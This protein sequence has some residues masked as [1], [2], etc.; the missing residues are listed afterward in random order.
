MRI[1]RD[2]MVRES[3]VSALEAEDRHRLRAFEISWLPTP[4]T[5]GLR[6]TPYSTTGLF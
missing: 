1:L 6:H 3:F 5:T 2:Q 4:T